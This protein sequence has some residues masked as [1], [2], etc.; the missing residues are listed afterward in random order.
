MLNKTLVLGASTKPERYSN[1]AIKMLIQHGYSV[2]AI[3]ARDGEVEGVKIQTGMPV[4]EDIHTVSMYL[5][6]KN[7]KNIYQYV[8]NLN[9]KRIIFNPGTE[10]IEFME[11][12]KQNNIEV[13]VACTLVLLSRDQF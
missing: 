6:P 1:K 2:E 10:N 8:I 12:I 3:G 13:E 4:F 9:P 7:Q 11:M 5:G